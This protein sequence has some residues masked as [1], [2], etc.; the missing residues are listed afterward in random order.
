MYKNIYGALFIIAQNWKQHHII[1]NSLNSTGIYIGISCTYLNVFYV[2]LYILPSKV[3]KAFHAQPHPLPQNN[4]CLQLLPRLIQLHHDLS[5]ARPLPTRY[6]EH[7]PV[8]LVTRTGKITCS[9][10]LPH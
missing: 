6:Q 5:P 2:S 8:T 1:D 4:V 10:E 9:R 7:L 3:F